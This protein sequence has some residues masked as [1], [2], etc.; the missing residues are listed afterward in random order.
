MYVYDLYLYV[1]DFMMRLVHDVYQKVVCL[2]A[3]GA[4]KIAM[5]DLRS[6]V[7]KGCSHRATE[8]LRLQILMHRKGLS[9]CGYT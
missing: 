9:I 1:L 6:R 4:I 5:L 8:A 3:I 7:V 2:H